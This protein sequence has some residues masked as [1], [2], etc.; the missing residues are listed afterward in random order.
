MAEFRGV[1]V[2]IATPFHADYSLD[3]EALRQHAEWL[4]GEGVHGLIPAG[5]CGEYASLSPSER[6]TV[7]ETVI[8]VAKGRVPVVV[9]VAAPSGLD[10]I[11]WAE[12]ARDHG[13]AG[14]MALPPVLYHPTWDEVVAY[15]TAL[16]RVALPIVIYNNPHDTT[17]DFTTARLQQLEHLSHIRAVKEFSQDIRRVNEI[18]TDTRFEVLAGADDLAL[19]CLWAGATGWVAGMVNILPRL[20]VN[21]YRLAEESRYDE[22]WA[23]YRRLLPI[24]RWD[25][26][27]RLVQALKY[28]ME[29]VGRPLGPTRPPRLGLTEEESRVVGDAVRSL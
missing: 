5:T 20:T 17:V 21:L 15:Y 24:L 13:A 27:P 16:D 2:A 28:G 10:V 23:L 22:A 29:M 12:H 11:H 25:S 8:D 14:I 19:E 1:Y 6:A 3:L 4:I 9:G 18:Q 26:T 7:V